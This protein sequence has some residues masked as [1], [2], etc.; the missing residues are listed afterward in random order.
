MK[1]M[2]DLVSIARAMRRK[3][4]APY[5]GYRVGAALLG[6]NGRVYRGCNVENASYGLTICAERSAIFQA[7][8]D[9]CRSF[10][11]LAIATADGGPP[12]GACL[13]VACEFGT[14]LRIILAS[15][16]RTATEGVLMDF[17][18]R[19]FRAKRWR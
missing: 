4:W 3:A 7:V 18:P 12:C 8:A 14:R 10:Q 16:S 9:G 19:P 1:K 5:S 13:Q 15:G 11:A 6:K 2:P 17:L